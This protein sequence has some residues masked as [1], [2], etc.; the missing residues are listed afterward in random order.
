MCSLGVLLGG[1]FVLV[2]GVFLFRRG[3][4][5]IDWGGVTYR[6]VGGGDVGMF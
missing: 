2:G 3:N 4:R 5:E 1:L 6:H